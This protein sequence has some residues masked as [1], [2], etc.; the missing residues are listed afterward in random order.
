MTSIKPTSELISSQREHPNITE[1]PSRD[2]SKWT[3]ISIKMKDLRF[4][5]NTNS[6]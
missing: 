1:L 2:S 4:L 6:E 5:D 3:T